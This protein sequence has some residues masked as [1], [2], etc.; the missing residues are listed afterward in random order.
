MSG[1]DGDANQVEDEC[2][3]VGGPYDG[4]TFSLPRGQLEYALPAEAPSLFAQLEDMLGE[5]NALTANLERVR[6]GEELLDEPDDDEEEYAQ[7]A[8]GGVLYRRGADGVTFHFVGHISV[9]E[10]ERRNGN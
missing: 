10:L 2:P 4:E 7:P 1:S 6:A 3:M 9:E 8:P 5:L